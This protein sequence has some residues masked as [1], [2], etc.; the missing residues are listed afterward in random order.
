MGFL[1]G[2]ETI[3]LT[4]GPVPV[5]EVKTGVIGLIGSAMEGEP[6]VMHVLRRRD[7]VAGVFGSASE[8]FSMHDAL[9]AIFDHGSTTVLAINVF[10]PLLDI[11]SETETLTSWDSNINYSINTVQLGHSNVRDV[12]ITEIILNDDTVLDATNTFEGPFTIDY[13]DGTVT[14]GEW[15]S[16]TLADN[17]GFMVSGSGLKSISISYNYLNLDNAAIRTR[18]VS[19]I[20][21]FENALS[22]F[23]FFPKILI[24]P[25]FSHEAGVGA[26]MVVVAN[27]CRGIALVDCPEGLTPEQAV[28]YKQSFSS[29]RCVVCYPK[30]KRLNPLSGIEDLDWL[31]SR[32]AGVMAKVDHEEGYW[33]SPSNHGIEG[34]TGVERVLSYAPNNED[35]ELNY[36]NSQGITS[37]LNF[38]GSGYRVFGNRT[39]AFPFG[40]SPVDTFICWRRVADCIEESIEY[41]T[42]QFLDKPMFTSPNNAQTELL[43]RVQESVNNYIRSLLGRGALV[44]GNCEIVAEDNPTS[45]LAAGHLVYR[46]YFTPPV[47]AER[48]TYK[49]IANIDALS[50]IFSSIIS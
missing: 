41:F 8:G 22:E 2:V 32:V 46:Y 14:W 23:G 12:A 21:N 6:N 13:V 20:H 18:I 35:S 31:S 36:V 26:E 30:V 7:D 43:A 48:I 50:T 44:D 4:Q 1:H 27:A 16:V 24:A 11:V 42:L 25:G 39:T 28:A 33:I 49:A 47:P 17:S 37:I 9:D 3:E 10:D 5:N 38:Y 29:N 45:E 40:T 15:I 19:S 34:I